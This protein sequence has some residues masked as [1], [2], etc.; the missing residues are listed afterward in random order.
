MSALPAQRAAQREASY[1]PVHLRPQPALL[2][3]QHLRRAR[4]SSRKRAASA[5]RRTGSAGAGVGSFGLAVAFAALSVP[6]VR[7]VATASAASAV[8]SDKH[9]RIAGGA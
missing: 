5:D 3:A 1:V 8:A 4:V 6:F 2:V 9:V 7:A